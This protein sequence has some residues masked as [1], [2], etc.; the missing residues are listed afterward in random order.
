MSETG[1]A[2]PSSSVAGWGHRTLLPDGLLVPIPS[3]SVPQGGPENP[4]RVVRGREVAVVPAEIEHVTV[5]LFEGRRGDSPRCHQR[6]LRRCAGSVDFV[7]ADLPVRVD[8]FGVE[9]TPDFGHVVFVL[10]EFQLADKQT[11]VANE[12][13]DNNHASYK[14]RQ[15]DRVRQRLMRGRKSRTLKLR[16]IDPNALDD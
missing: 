12:L 6:R 9:P 8:S 15:H 11:A 3:E 13:G 14:M 16:K 7:Q 5:V 4:G 2:R 1:T 10:T